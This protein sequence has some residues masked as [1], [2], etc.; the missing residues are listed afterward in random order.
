MATYTGTPGNDVWPPSGTD[1]S[2]ADQGEI[3]KN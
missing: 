2:G 1:N 3:A